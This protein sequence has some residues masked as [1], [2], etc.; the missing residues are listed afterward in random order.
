MTW[1]GRRPRKARKTPTSRRTNGSSSSSRKRRTR[2]PTSARTPRS[3]SGE[4][5]AVGRQVERTRRKKVVIAG[6]SAPV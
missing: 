4:R 3:T 1:Q 5:R 2:S 6:Q